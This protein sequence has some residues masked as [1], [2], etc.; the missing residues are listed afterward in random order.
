MPDL[1]LDTNSTRRQRFLSQLPC[2]FGVTVYKRRS[3][4]SQE[5]GAQPSFQIWC[6]SK[7]NDVKVSPLIVTGAKIFDYVGP[8]IHSLSE[9]TFE[10]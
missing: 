8:H 7:V 3:P 1:R 6:P 2:P 10:K 5:T 4:S 9:P